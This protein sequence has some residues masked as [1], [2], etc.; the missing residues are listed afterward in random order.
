MSEPAPATGVRGLLNSQSGH[1]RLRPPNR[2]ASAPNITAHCHPGLPAYMQLGA[3]TGACSESPPHF[4][5]CLSAEAKGTASTPF[6]LL[7]LLGGH[8]VGRSTAHP[9]LGRREQGLDGG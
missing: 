6:P 4:V 9:N 3:D 8:A 2:A 5:T 1:P 7:D